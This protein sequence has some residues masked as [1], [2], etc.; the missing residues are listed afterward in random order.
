MKI[1]LARLVL[2]LIILL[3]VSPVLAQEG[4]ITHTITYD[5]FTFSYGDGITLTITQYP[6][7]APDTMMPGGPDVRH[8]VFTLSEDVSTTTIVV[9]NAVDFTGYE[10]HLGQ[11]Q[12]LYDLLTTRPD[13][14]AYTTLPILPPPAGMQSLVAH[15]SYVD[16]GSVVGIAYITNFRFDV[17]PF[18]STDFVYTFQGL[19]GKG[20]YVV[21]VQTW[22]TTSLFPSSPDG[23]PMISSDAEWQQELSNAISVLNSAAPDAFSPALTS[24]DDLVA[25]FSF[26]E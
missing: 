4:A 8:N 1:R 24:V 6:G 19:S 22:L 23:L 17:S 10:S 25:T 11:L 3:G 16:T 20:Q 2:V 14:T 13:L 18:M 5:G 26:A 7:D 21:A 9:Y 15:A 12:T